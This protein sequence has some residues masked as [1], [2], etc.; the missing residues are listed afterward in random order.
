M[1]MVCPQL[2]LGSSHM[3]R[4]PYTRVHIWLFWALRRNILPAGYLQ[5]S[6]ED[7]QVRALCRAGRACVAGF[8]NETRDQIVL[9]ARNGNEEAREICRQH[10]IPW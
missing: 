2:E 3:E 8:L 10:G 6:V 7:L 4:G 1:R 9:Q 5:D